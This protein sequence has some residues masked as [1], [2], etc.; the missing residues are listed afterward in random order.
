MM[1]TKDRRPI[2]E[3]LLA[4][5]TE[6]EAERW[7]AKRQPQFNACPFLYLMSGRDPEL[8][9]EIIDQMESGTQP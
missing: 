1:N 6:D 8:V 7:L 2:P 5:Y 3:R 4:F 9:H